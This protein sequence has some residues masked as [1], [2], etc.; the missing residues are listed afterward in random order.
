MNAA[1]FA[2]KQQLRAAMRQKLAALSQD[3]IREQSMSWTRVLLQCRL[4]K[5]L[6]TLRKRSQAKT[7]TLGC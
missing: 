7:S 2:A 5:V 4:L 1:L 3:A 6:A